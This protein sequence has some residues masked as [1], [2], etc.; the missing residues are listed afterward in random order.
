MRHVLIV[1]DNS[2]DMQQATRLLQKLGAQDIQATSS[3]A[4]ALKYLREAAEGSKEIPDLLVL[5]LEFNQESGF[6]VLRYWKAN[7][8]LHKMYIIVWTHMGD[9]EQKISE[10]FGVKRVVDKR[11]GIKELEKALR[12][13]L[14]VDKAS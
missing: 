7:P 4:F 13:I 2:T 6:E 3:V 10:L 8:K 1:E 12:G 5:D 14:A 9:L 11:L